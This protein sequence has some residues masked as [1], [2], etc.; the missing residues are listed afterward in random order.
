VEHDLLRRIKNVVVALFVSLNN[1]RTSEFF[2]SWTNS[3]QIFH[4]ELKLFR[5]VFL[6]TTEVFLVS[7][8]EP[9][10]ITAVVK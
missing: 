5:E 8:K 7:S 1:F 9:I 2:R 10:M 3:D 6:V 4:S